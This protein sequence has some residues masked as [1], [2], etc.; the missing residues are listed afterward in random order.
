MPARSRIRALSLA[1]GLLFA[2]LLI[3]RTQVTFSDLAQ[4]GG[5]TAL[6]PVAHEGAL[7]VGLPPDG[8]SLVTAD[9]SRMVTWDLRTGERTEETPSSRGVYGREARSVALAGSAGLGIFSAFPSTFVLPL[10]SGAVAWRVPFLTWGAPS[11][12][13]RLVFGFTNRRWE[14]MVYEVGTR[15]V[16]ARHRAPDGQRYRRAAVSSDGRWM[17]AVCA[18]EWQQGTTLWAVDLRT[19]MDRRLREIPMPGHA[20]L[21]FSPDGDTLAVHT[22]AGPDRRL[23]TWRTG[24]WA[25][26]ASFSTGEGVDLLFRYSPDGGA[27]ATTAGVERDYLVGALGLERRRETV[28]AL[29]ILDPV[30]G[31][32]LLPRESPERARGHRAPLQDLAWSADG[33]T[34]AT[35]DVDGRIGLWDVKNSRFARFVRG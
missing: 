11:A 16:L 32:P 7:A 19:G 25:P 1:A 18:G 22:G 12:D 30:S 3:H 17:A 15:R 6:E 8:R 13:G 29:L 10:R 14:L 34:V 4:L 23:E 33:S 28:N 26:L 9:G 35:L 31:R 27:I 5:P 21:A 20:E 2:F 24:K